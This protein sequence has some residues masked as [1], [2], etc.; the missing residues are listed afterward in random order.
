MV[1]T[2]SFLLLLIFPFSS[3]SQNVKGL[4]QDARQQESA[5]H[6][7]EAFLRYAEVL[8][9]EPDNLVALCKC[10]E[11]S[12][13]IGARQTGKE[14]MREYF[15][16]ARNYAS[17]ALRRDSS[18]SDAN[19]VMALAL[20][21]LSLIAGT[22]ERIELARGIK[23]YAEISIRLDP[24]NFKP[25]HILG[26]WNFEVSNL[27]VAEKS[28]AKIIYGGLPP[29]SLKQSIYYF[30]KS[31]TLNPAF[32]RNYLELARAYHRNNNDKKAME[33]LHTL[34]GLPNMIYDDARVKTTA[35]ELIR[36]WQ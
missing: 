29:A 20:G 31:R 11:L 7:N 33:L 9:L 2:L 27:N 8:K 19:F 10:S 30:E 36:E 15:I 34:L 13:R 4:I 22:R 5:F 35:N 28:I 14:K 25:Y 24:S 32:L 18:S 23:K 17:R 1:R 26:K 21:R 12:S 16:A 6:E 3:F